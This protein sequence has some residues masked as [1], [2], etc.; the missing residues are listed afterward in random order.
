MAALTST[1]S[2]KVF[3]RCLDIFILTI[4]SGLTGTKRVI[5]YPAGDYFTHCIP[6][7]RSGQSPMEILHPGR[8]S[9]SVDDWDF[10]AEMIARAPAFVASSQCGSVYGI[11]IVPDPVNKYL[12]PINT[13]IGK[14]MGYTA[15]SGVLLESVLLRYLAMPD[16]QKRQIC[17]ELFPLN[18]EST[19]LSESG[20]A[21]LMAE[22]TSALIRLL[23]KRCF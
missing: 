9:D 12:Q 15:Q 4:V 20:Y 19:K 1:S 2:R 8:E 13:Y 18:T 17:E 16:S 23:E 10:G 3:N 22:M 21:K 7:N 11:I 5:N 6:L 14:G